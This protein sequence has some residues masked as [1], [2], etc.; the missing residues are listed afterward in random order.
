MRL[1]VSTSDGP[2]SRWFGSAPTAVLAVMVAAGC[3]DGYVGSDG[4]EPDAGADTSVSDTLGDP[5]D[6]GR[7]DTDGTERDGGGSDAAD[8]DESDGGPNTCVPEGDGRIQ[9]EEVPFEAGLQATFRVA[10]DVTVDT[11]GTEQN[12]T[13]WH[14]GQSRNTRT[15]PRD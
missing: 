9:R 13:Y 15:S 11:A 5:D 14:T 8:G 7:S 6:T 10:E 1:D 12:F 3:T 4:G 2:V